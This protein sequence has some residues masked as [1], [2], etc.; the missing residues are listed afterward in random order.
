MLHKFFYGSNSEFQQKNILILNLNPFSTWSCQ[1]LLIKESERN[2]NISH[3]HLLNNLKTKKPIY[4][5]NTGFGKLSN[6]F[7]EAED[8]EKI[9]SKFNSKSCMWDWETT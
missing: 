8:L 4:G 5:V 3:K 7:I 1:C 9:T 2:I 6:K